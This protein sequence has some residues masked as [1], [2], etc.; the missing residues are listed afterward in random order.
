MLPIITSPHHADKPNKSEAVP[1]ASRL[2]C[3][4]TWCCV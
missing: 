1:V 3:S 2:Q 4:R